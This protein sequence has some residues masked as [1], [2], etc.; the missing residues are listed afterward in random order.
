MSERDIDE[1]HIVATRS[2]TVYIEP[3]TELDRA[4]RETDPANVV[5]ESRGTRYRLLRDTAEPD[6][7][8]DYDP[9]ASLAGTV[10][11]AGHWRD[12]DA[13]AFKEEIRKRR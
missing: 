12:F 13:E 3:D 8:H 9:A 7:W 4:L 1:V 2:R 6:I 11:T 10:N 5:I